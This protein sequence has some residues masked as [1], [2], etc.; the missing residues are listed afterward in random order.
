MDIVDKIIDMFSNDKSSDNKPQ[1]S[2]E[3]DQSI[4]R[5]AALKWDEYEKTKVRLALI[6]QPGAGKSSIINSLLGT[7]LFPV[8]V[9]TDTTV[10]AQEKEFGGL[11]ITD[12]PGY[13]TAR[14]PLEVWLEEFQ[15]EQYDMYLFV[16]DGKLHE[17]DSQLFRYLE[18]WQQE[19]QHPFF[20]VRNKEDQIW[21]DE[22][23]L[24]HL[25]EEIQ[26]DVRSLL[27]DEDTPIFFTSCRHQTGIEA[28][29]RA[30]YKMDFDDVK[31]S[32]I[33]AS[34][35]ATCLEDLERK[36]VI[37]RNNLDM[38]AYAAA[39]NGLNPLPGVDISVDLGV[40]Y[41][42]LKDI[43]ETFGITDEQK[44]KRYEILG[45][46][47]KKLIDEV[48]QYM[49]EN[50]ANKLP[51][52]LAKAFGKRFTEKQFAKLIP[53]VGNVVSALLG[54]A[55]TKK[56]GEKYIDDCFELSKML[57]EHSIEKRH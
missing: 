48:C 29:K 10:K 55:M 45:P 43:R 20:L 34:F 50:Y 53:L 26:A 8:G 13:G 35:K 15:P 38:Y 1:K 31:K 57:M 25:K 28:L 18:K 51:I 17:A 36:R 46:T 7:K 49:V 41:S 22:K 27:N 37:C 12:L 33:V 23:T 3:L 39:A 47:A 40:F 6:G 32:K 16:F 54:A 52:G 42:M 56:V 14:F 9:Y 44:I 30:I 2:E 4:K 11:I 21:D 19:R 5:K 24:E